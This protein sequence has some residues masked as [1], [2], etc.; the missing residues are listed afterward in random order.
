MLIADVDEVVVPLKHGNWREMLEHVIDAPESR[1]SAVSIRN[2][3]KFL[4]TTKNGTE[5]ESLLENK[6]RSSI[7]Q[8]R[9]QY[10]KSFMK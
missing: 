5:D 6:Y 8:D 4:S 2:V 7:I 10:G 9:E 1:S 3:F